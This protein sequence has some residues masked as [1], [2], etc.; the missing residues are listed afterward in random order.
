MITEL[1]K[2]KALET[3]TEDQLISKA[4]LLMDFQKQQ[5]GYIDCELVKSVEENGWY[6]IYH[7][8]SL[9]KVKVNG[10]KLRKNPAFERLMQLLI[11]ESVHVSF[12]NKVKTW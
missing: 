9:E 5:D 6:F 12:Y 2:F 8:E 1:V 4:E 3:T 10:E 11:P 7:Y